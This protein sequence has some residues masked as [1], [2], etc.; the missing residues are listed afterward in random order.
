MGDKTINPKARRPAMNSIVTDS[1]S[2][3]NFD[4]SF[5][6]AALEK[7]LSDSEVE[8]I[9]RQYGHRWRDR[10][11]PPGVTVRSLVYRSLNPDKSIK[12]TLADLIAGDPT[13]TLD[14]TDSAW[15][16]A[17]SRLPQELMDKLV[18]HSDQRLSEI[19]GLDYRYQNREVY[20][21]DGSTVSTED[22][23]DLA[24]AFGYA[25][26]KHGASRFPVARITL[27]VRAGVD[28]IYD[29]RVGP[30]RTGEQA[31][32]YE[33]WHRIPQNSIVIS[34]K[35]FCS[36]YI[37]AKF[38]E[39]NIDTIMP[40]HQKRDP[41]KL[42]NRGISIGQ[43]QWI[44]TFNLSRQL[45]HK[46][47]DPSLPQCLKVRLI[48]VRYQRSGK[49][50]TQWLVTTL[51]DH[52]C[53]PKR[54]IVTLYRKRWGIETRIG[55]VKTTLEM[56]TPRSKGCAAVLMEIAA[57][58][59]AHNL[60]QTVIHQAAKRTKTPA[61][62]I[63]FAGTIKTILAFSDRLR[64]TDRS[65]RVEVYNRMLDQVAGN[66]NPHRPGRVEPRLVKREQRRYGF[67]K[68]PRQQAREGL[69]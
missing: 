64:T 52:Q 36:F 50:K 22:T 14:V 35:N 19:A 39:R 12:G 28:S 49:W 8:V 46:Y 34:D 23:A 31:Q 69:S 2:H 25:D 44:V 65:D 53:Y 40:L 56:G 30:Y 7:Y 55:A 59:L 45:R 24:D 32:L 4:R 6:V 42:I 20:L 68:I 1:K 26:S 60:I 16:Q 38:Q 10:N 11:L 66:T 33:M 9:C 51:L 37:L 27:L 29:Y 67:L 43:N 48:R 18:L 5:Q 15:C 63:S 47:N 21:V 41:L 58:I 62:R 61:E 57:T 3:H 17:R 13:N 54:D